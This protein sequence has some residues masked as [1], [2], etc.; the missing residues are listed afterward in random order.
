M[1]TVALI[2]RCALYLQRTGLFAVRALPWLLLFALGFYFGDSW[3]AVRFVKMPEDLAWEYGDE[4]LQWYSKYE[5]CFDPDD[6]VKA[7]AN[8]QDFDDSWVLE[9]AIR[10]EGFEGAHLYISIFDGGDIKAF[11]GARL[12]A[13]TEHRRTQPG[14]CASEPDWN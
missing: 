10:A 1:N 13:A 12:E 11:P 2:A 7:G 9:Y 4:Y 3:T 8:Y 6:A 14:A 5:F